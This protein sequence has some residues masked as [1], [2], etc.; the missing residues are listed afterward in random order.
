MAEAQRT[1]PELVP[2][3]LQ[4]VVGQ[5]QVQ[6]HGRPVRAQAPGHVQQVALG[7][8]AGLGVPQVQRCQGEASP[9]AQPGPLGAP[10]PLWGG[11]GLLR[12][13]ASAAAP[14]HT[15]PP[16]QARTGSLMG[17]VAI[18]R[19]SAPRLC[20]AASA[21]SGTSSGAGPR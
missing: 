16:P 11:T 21:S 1:P 13:L 5:A 14:S 15:P 8:E 4:L 18:H 7:Q 12:A 17:R 9:S 19:A 10:Q 20:R 2:D 6:G 3:A